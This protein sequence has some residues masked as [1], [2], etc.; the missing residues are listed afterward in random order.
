MNSNFIFNGGNS[1][2]AMS[3]VELVKQ[4]YLSL[5]AHYLFDLIL[6][7]TFGD[8]LYYINNPHQQT[9]EH[10]LIEYS[11]S[12]LS[13]LPTTIQSNLNR[14]WSIHRCS[15]IFLHDKNYFTHEYF[16]FPEELIFSPKNLTLNWKSSMNKCI[17][18]S[19]SIVLLDD[20]RQ[21]VIIGSHA[22]LIN[23]Y[24]I[25]NGKLIWSFQ[26]NDR[27]EATGSISRTGQFFLIGKSF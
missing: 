3:F 2:L 9:Q 20:K 8:L 18:A 14:I 16:S 12:N 21:Y 22:G 4:H 13:T 7:K 15:R 5:D 26:A 1:M 10:Q 23:A 6:H 24:Q 17:D 25:D 19:P 27:I 11:S